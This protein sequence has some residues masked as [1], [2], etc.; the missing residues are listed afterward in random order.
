MNQQPLMPKTALI[1]VSDKTGLREFAHELIRNGITL[2]STGGTATFLTEAGIAVHHISEITSFP[3]IMEGRLKTLHPKLLGG[4]LGKR[5]Q[6]VKEAEQHQIPWIDMVVCNLYPFS[7]TIE[8]D[9]NN[10]E[11][12]VEN[13]DIGGPTMIRAAAKNFDWVT[14]ISDQCDYQ[15]IAHALNK[16]GVT[17]PLRKQ[18]AQ[19]A[20]AHVSL[21]DKKISDYLFQSDHDTPI[22]QSYTKIISLRYGENPH[23]S[24]TLCRSSEACLTVL[25]A[26]QLQGKQMSYN[27]YVDAQ[28]AL[29][30]VVECNIPTVAVIKHA[31]PCGLASHTSSTEA[32]CNAFYADK[33]SAFGGVVALNCLVDESIADKIAGHFFEIIIAP[34]FSREALEVL[35]KK[36]NLRLLCVDFKQPV[37]A[38][39]YQ[40]LPGGLLVQSS[41]N[42]GLNLNACT[43]VTKKDIRKKIE[44]EL[45]F[46]WHAVR[47]IKSNAI[48]IT[49]NKTTVGIGGGQVSRVDAAKHAI[50]KAGKDAVNAILASDGFFPF[51]DCV[52]L[53]AQAGIKI[54]IQ[55]GGSKR[56]QEVIDACN[57]HGIAM[58]FTHQRV[59]RH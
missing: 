7:K 58:L 50:D 39:H 45:E 4:V 53:A 13:I 38:Y 27:N 40:F 8:A 1:S 49:N 33:Q 18:L 9:P 51:R 10:L 32:F 48:V 44:S 46:A 35:K 3:E 19:K 5:D 29:D 6:H 22:T 52:D 17:Y 12:A 56:D 20:F 31:M 43:L 21:Y 28:A 36:S 37:S 23:Q 30:C 47:Q 59:F 14:V 54:I 2:Y 24:A 42:Q 25:D 16:G 11:R 57:E 34:E 26:E 15:K 55:P 41:D